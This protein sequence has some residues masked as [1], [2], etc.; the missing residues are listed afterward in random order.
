MMKAQLDFLFQSCHLQ[1]YLWLALGLAFFLGICAAPRYFH[2]RAKK[3]KDG[4]ELGL[5]LRSGETVR[6]VIWDA[7]IHLVGLL[8]APTLLLFALLIS[9]A[10]D[11]AEKI[12]LGILFLP[13]FFY[14]LFCVSGH[15]RDILY[16]TTKT[17]IKSID[18][19]WHGI[20][21]EFGSKDLDKLEQGAAR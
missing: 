4:K 17:G 1:F 9:A 8:L 13:L 5:W 10:P 2:D 16:Q 19:T 3:D 20:K 15:G 6:C 7:L 12:I 11:S 21:I 14:M 18:I